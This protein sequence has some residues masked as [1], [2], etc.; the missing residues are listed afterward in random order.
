M[1]AYIKLSTNEY[2]RHDGD[3]ALDPTGEYVA[4]QWV[5]APA[6]DD[7]TQRCG[8]GAPEQVDGQWRMT[9]I[10]RDATQEEIDMANKPLNFFLK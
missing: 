2:P 1:T 4:V 9:W 6:F 3:I 8:E 7:A 10:V 5:D